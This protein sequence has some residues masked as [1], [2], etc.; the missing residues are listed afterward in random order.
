MLKIY[1]DYVFVENSRLSRIEGS[2]APSSFNLLLFAA[3]LVP[4][5]DVHQ[6]PRVLAEFKLKLTL[7]VNNQLAGGIE[8]APALFL[9]G[10][11]QVD[12][13]GSQVEGRAR[14]VVHGLTDPDP[15]VGGEANPAAGGRFNHAN[16]TELGAQSTCN[17]DAANGRRL[18]ER[19]NQALVLALLECGNKGVSLFIRGV[20]GNNDFYADSLTQL[21]ARTHRRSVNRLCGVFIRPLLL[22]GNS[23]GNRRQQQNSEQ[24]SAVEE[25][26]GH[27]HRIV[28][29]H[30][31]LSPMTALL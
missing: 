2:P 26:A 1:R 28:V 11:V 24:K 12:L 31:F 9:I 30:C 5:D 25:F 29:Y 19:L 13:T 6:I 8:D 3:G 18:A 4:V 14:A 10:V 15:A 22:C 23:R 27:R 7:F 16:I 17:G 20:S 21:G